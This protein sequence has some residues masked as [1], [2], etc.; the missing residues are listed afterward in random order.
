MSNGFKILKFVL[1]F[2]WKPLLQMFLVLFTLAIIGS[3]DFVSVFLSVLVWLLVFKLFSGVPVF[4]EWVSSVVKTFLIVGFFYFV[5][6][7]LGGFGL[8]GVVCILL[9]LA[10]WRIYQSWSLFDRV[11]SWG[12]DRLFRGGKDDFEFEEVKK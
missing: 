8:L 4:S 5:I 1:F 7:W 9:L 10:G 12:A 3:V 2:L 11:T 6:L